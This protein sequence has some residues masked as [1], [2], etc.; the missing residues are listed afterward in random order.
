MGFGGWAVCITVNQ[1]DQLPPLW[2]QTGTQHARCI[3]VTPPV[4]NVIPRQPS[5]AFPLGANN[6]LGAKRRPGD[7]RK[8]S[9]TL[10]RNQRR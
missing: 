8:V 7:F 1:T 5:S 9:V 2:F 4:P 10:P 3:G 6:F